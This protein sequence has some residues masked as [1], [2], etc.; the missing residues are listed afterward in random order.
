M[1]L[2][3]ASRRRHP[4]N[5]CSHQLT[6]PLKAP[7]EMI[8]LPKWHLSTEWLLCQKTPLLRMTTP[9][10][11]HFLFRRLSKDPLFQTSLSSEHPLPWDNTSPPQK[12]HL[13]P[14]HHSPDRCANK[15]NNNIIIYYYL[16]NP[17]I[18]CNTWIIYIPEYY[19]SLNTLY[20]WILYIPEY[21][22]LLNII[23]PW[24]IYI[25]ITTQ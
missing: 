9:A 17:W 16:Y 1:P 14:E 6:L 10:R 12:T 3:M 4:P 7:I 20:S 23:Y 24:I 25:L 2:K 22:I 18:L 8:P 11:R 19:I 21:Y 15:K 13:S 5:S